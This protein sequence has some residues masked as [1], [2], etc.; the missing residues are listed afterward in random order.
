VK[1]KSIRSFFRFTKD[2]MRNLA[3]GF[4][5]GTSGWPVGLAHAELA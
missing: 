4:P 1:A 3:G 5:I 2:Q